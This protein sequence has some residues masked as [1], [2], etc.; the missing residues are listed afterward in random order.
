MIVLAELGSRSSVDAQARQ[1]HAST[2][3]SHMNEGQEELQPWQETRRLKEGTWQW[4]DHPDKEDPLQSYSWRGPLS[5]CPPLQL[6]STL[7]LKNGKRVFWGLEGGLL[8]TEDLIGIRR[9]WIP[10]WLW[11]WLNPEMSSKLLVIEKIWQNKQKVSLYKQDPSSSTLTKPVCLSLSFSWIMLR[12]ILLALGGLLQDYWRLWVWPLTT[13]LSNTS[14][15]CLHVSSPA[16]LW[17]INIYKCIWCFD[18][19][20]L[21]CF[22]DCAGVFL[23][24]AVPLLSKMFCFSI[25]SIS[26]VIYFRRSGFSFR[27][28]S[29]P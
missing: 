29:V 5:L 6:P 7:L 3:S 14:V 20:V 22:A 28:P 9:L 13:Y 11:F 26:F 27:C 25:K 8:W 4:E 1:G 19:R 10:F 21:L 2:S 18:K 16:L 24:Q 15:G 23:C 12:K 17:K